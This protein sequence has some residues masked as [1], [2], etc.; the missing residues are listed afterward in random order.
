M[1]CTFTN[2]KQQATGR[3]V[4][5]KVTDP[6]PDPAGTSF[7]FTAGGGL[8]SA[9]FSIADGGS[10]TFDELE[11]KAGY[12]LVEWRTPRLGRGEREL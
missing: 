10:R 2:R 11:P 12:R 8:E 3:I 1:T 6:S 5:R 9:E 7:D 4:V